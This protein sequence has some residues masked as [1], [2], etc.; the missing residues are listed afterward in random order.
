VSNGYQFNW[1]TSTAS[2][3]GPGCYTV[4][5][6]LKDDS[7]GSPNFTVLDPVRLKLASVQLK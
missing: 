7:S 3:T 4:V 2:G 5:F 6:Q 1:A